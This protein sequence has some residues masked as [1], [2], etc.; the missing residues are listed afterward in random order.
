MIEFK[1]Y[2]STIEEELRKT[3]FLMAPGKLFL[4]QIK[5]WFPR[6][7]TGAF[8]ENHALNGYCQQL[9]NHTGHE[10]DE[11]KMYIKRQ[12]IKRGLRIDK[13]RL[14]P[15]GEAVPI[16]ERDMTSQEAKWCIKECLLLADFHDYK[17]RGDNR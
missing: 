15:E 16:S 4:V 9:A 3:L 1:A 12:A 7:S 14:G 13:N 8:S 17:L 10:F 2:Q 11:I 6:R 5:R